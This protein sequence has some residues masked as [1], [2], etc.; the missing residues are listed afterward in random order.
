VPLS[1]FYQRIRFHAARQLPIQVIKM[2]KV[3]TSEFEI[4][5][6]PIKTPVERARYEHAMKLL[7]GL[8]A[9]ALDQINAMDAAEEAK[10]ILEGDASHANNTTPNPA[11]NENEINQSFPGPTPR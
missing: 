9:E 8:F 11:D 7:A 5:Y 2:K 4:R 6:V 10:K 3:F 1:L